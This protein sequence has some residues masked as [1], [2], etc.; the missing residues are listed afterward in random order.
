M[1]HFDIKKRFVN[2][3]LLGYFVFIFVL[4]I[5]CFIIGLE[6]NKQPFI[7]RFFEPAFN[8]SSSS[9]GLPPMSIDVTRIRYEDGFQLI[10]IGGQK[11]GKN[12]LFSMIINNYNFSDS[13]M[14]KLE[15]ESQKIIETEVILNPIPFSVQL[16]YF[17]LPLLIAWM[18]FVTGLIAF[19]DQL[20][21]SQQSGLPIFFGA[22]AVVFGTIYDVISTH[23]VFPIWIAAI[24]LAAIGFFQF[25][26]EQFKPFRFRNQLIGFGYLCAF[27]ISFFT[28][29]KP[30]GFEFPMNF[31]TY[32]KPVLFLSIPLIFISQIAIIISTFLSKAPNEKQYRGSFSISG[33]LSFLLII[34]WFTLFLFNSNIKLD[35]WL[36]F[37]L[38]ILP[39]TYLAFRFKFLEKKQEKF[40]NLVLENLILSGLITL[41]YGFIVTGLGL[42]FFGKV[43]INNPFLMGFL[44]FLISLSVFPLKTYLDKFVKSQFDLTLDSFKNRITTFRGD[45]KDLIKLDDI[46]N[47]LRLDIQEAVQSQYV[48]IFL[49][50]S[51]TNLFK[52]T[53]FGD[54]RSSDLVFDQNSSFVKFLS[55]ETKSQLIDDRGVVPPLLKPEINRLRL[56]GGKLFIP[57]QGQKQLLGWVAMSNRLDGETFSAS[58]INYL[59]TIVSQTSLA[60]ERSL[61]IDSLER[62][63]FE[64]NILTKVAQ[65]VNYTVELND[66]YEL[67][68]TQISQIYTPDI[69][70]IL[71]KKSNESSIT[72]V[73]YTENSERIFSEENKEIESVDSL[74]AIII[75]NGRVFYAEDYLSEC[76]DR[77]AQ[78]IREK[79]SS[80][81]FVPLN[82][83]AE[84]IG[85]FLFGQYS[86]LH[87]LSADQISLFQALADQIAGAIIKAKIFQESEHRAQQLSKLNQLNQ[88]LTANLN[89]QPLFLDILNISMEIINCK[90]GAI[91]IFDPVTK[92]FRAQASIGFSNIEEETEKISFSSEFYEPIIMDN[93]NEKIDNNIDLFVKI[94]LE[95]NS[96]RKKSSILLVPMILKGE[97]LGLIKLEDHVDG[98]PFTTNDKE[99]L[100]TFA[101]QAS[102]AIDNARLYSSTDQALAAKVEELSIMQRIDRELNLSL[103]LQR[104]LDITLHWAIRRAKAC[105][106]FIGLITIEGIRIEVYEG[107]Q[108]EILSEYLNKILPLTFLGLDSVFFDGQPRLKKV[109]EQDI[110]FYE[111][112]K[113]Q[114]LVPIR[115]KE[116]PLAF[117]FLEFDSEEMIDDQSLE[118]LIRLS[119]HASIALVNGQLY[120]EVRS[121]NLAKSE[122][123]S[124]VAHELK[125][126]MTSIKGYTE[127]L[128]AGTVGEINEAQSNFLSTISSNVDRM[129]TLVSDLNDLTKIEAGRLRLEFK[130]VDIKSV[131]EEVIQS[132][133]RFLDEKNQK[134]TLTFPIDLP[135]VWADPTRLSQILINL[136]NNAHKY[137]DNGTEIS[138]GANVEVN[139]VNNLYQ[140]DVVH[141]WV[142]DAGIGI[143]QDD[144]KKVFQKFF[145]SEDPKAREV[146]GTG[147]GLNITKS[148]VELQGGSI[149]FESE[150]RKGSIFHLLV[151]INKATD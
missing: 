52:A 73:F 120:A 74:E 24:P 62:R 83:G 38:A 53:F 23:H 33:F 28:W 14:I 118:F 105:A 81:L 132:N 65:G 104:V 49:F 100:T 60:I 39:I 144:Q 123:V 137:S 101:A 107:Y 25:T 133:R 71:L 51:N 135:K 95:T 44:F 26:L 103:D 112:T 2:G 139:Q 1:D 55:K 149:W 45:L 102:I 76:K 20:I 17:Y 57:I 27:T 32:I 11:I 138:I 48:H 116:N 129:N 140:Q 113:T 10:E 43:N 6:W 130:P 127:L 46:V 31:L 12:D 47:L 70:A 87:K 94:N 125:N 92:E 108:T 146:P 5:Y 84:T 41:G 22:M 16:Y 151:P 145:R 148:M 34:V 69:F 109:T 72:Q 3:L 142:K 67:I 68:Y 61:V 136:V 88:K 7:G 36:T 40:G 119:E 97:L 134:V 37:P 141:L 21:L 18:F 121:A 54:Q 85:L 90:K 147:L 13:V 126:P 93:S 56:L 114:I 124:L 4:L 96:S 89:L 82:A 106:G 86:N 117:I 42:L 128:S 115:R 78:Y 122:F 98:L 143:K 50:D 15:S 9:I 131:I 35:I 30:F 66:I 75:K 91:L 80:A 79:V 29:I 99:I 64:S 150:F 59:N 58:E 110:C 77:S 19:K 8:V 111:N 63:N